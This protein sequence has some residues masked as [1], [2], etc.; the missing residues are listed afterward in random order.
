[1][2]GASPETMA[3]TVATPL[4]KQFGSIPGVET[5][6]TSNERGWTSITI[7]F[8]LNRNIDAAAVDVQAAIASARTLLPQEMKDQLNLTPRS[9]TPACWT[10]PLLGLP[11]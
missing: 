10:E 11:M 7:E 9:S 3:T 6:A 8:A 4:I 5:I 1:M 2:P